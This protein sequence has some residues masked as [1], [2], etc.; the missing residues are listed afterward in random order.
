MSLFVLLGLHTILCGERCVSTNVC[1]Q[2]CLLARVN[3]CSVT[4]DGQTGLHYNATLIR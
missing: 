3:L 2:T 4:D 1:A